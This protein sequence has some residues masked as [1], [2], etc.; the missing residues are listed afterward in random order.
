M[1]ET[2]EEQPPLVFDW[3]T[4]HQLAH[5]DAGRAMVMGLSMISEQLDYLIRKM[6]SDG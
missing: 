4:A 5:R 2:P 6:N 1:S 3:D